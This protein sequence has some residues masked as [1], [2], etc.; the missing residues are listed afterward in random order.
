M[1]SGCVDLPLQELTLSRSRVTVPRWKVPGMLRAV[2]LTQPLAPCRP[3]SATASSTLTPSSKMPRARTRMTSSSGRR[4][5]SRCATH[6]V[7]VCTTHT[8]ARTRAH[9]RAPHPNRTRPNSI[10]AIVNPARLTRRSARAR[11]S[12]PWAG[13]P[14]KGSRLRC[15]MLLATERTSTVGRPPGMRPSETARERFCSLASR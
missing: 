9:I 1:R 5:S 10:N 2:H 12:P 13:H 8:H 3:Q 4:T 6:G 11:T 14:P 7:R 15:T